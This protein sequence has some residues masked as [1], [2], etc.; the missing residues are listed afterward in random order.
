MRKRKQSPAEDFME[1]MAS[2]P[3][4]VGVVAAIGSYIFLHQLAAPPK[5]DPT[6]V[7]DAIG[8]MW[9]G[10]LAFY[11]QYFVPV[12]CLVGAAVSFARRKKR[13]SLFD[14]VV[15]AKGADALSGMTWREFEMLVGEAFRVQG[16]SVV[17]LGGAA[18]DGGV[19][20]VLRKGN[21]KFL[22]Q[23]KHWKAYKVGVDVVRELYGVM[24]AQGAAGGFVI[25][26]GSFTSD[27][28]DFAAGRN[29]KLID[30][31]KLL[32]LIQQGRQAAG[33]RSSVAA[34]ISPPAVH[35]PTAYPS[36]PICS[37]DMVRRTA[38]KGTKAGS[39]FWGCSRYPACKGTRA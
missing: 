36:C 14:N 32:G 13:K 11:G 19:D 8:R 28:Q 35:M 10:S 2:L 38:K 30:G 29:L 17:E 4:L 39:Q 12:L 6:R 23:C 15:Q 1:I 24:A 16:Y 34:P 25:T 9:V 26:S 31:P 37:C 20:L 21:E 18:P 22:V 5:V 3:W 7:A 33:E 27:A